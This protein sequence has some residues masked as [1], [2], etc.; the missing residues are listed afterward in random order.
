ME[1]KTLGGFVA[2]LALSMGS[3][4]G[5]GCGGDPS[6]D[7]SATNWGGGDD[8]TAGG[9]G[10]T[11]DDG[12]TGDD[13]GPEDDGDADAGDDNDGGSAG[14]DAD[15]GGDDGGVCSDRVCDE[16]ESCE[17]CP[18]D[19]GACDNPEG[20]PPEVPTPWDG[21]DSIPENSEVIESPSQSADVVFSCTGSP[22]NIVG[23]TANEPIVGTTDDTVTIN[24]SYCVIHDIVFEGYTVRVDGDHYVIRDSE[25]NGAGRTG[26]NGLSLAGSDGVA[27]RNASHHLL[28][29]DRHCYTNG[30]GATD[31]W[32]IENEGYYCTGDGY[33]AGHQQEAN[34]PT[35]IY[36]V[37][38][39]LHDNREN[40]L[41]YKFVQNVWAVENTLHGFA[42]A[43][44][45]EPWCFPDAPDQCSTSNSG[46]DGSAVVVGSD[47]GPIDSYHLRNVIYD[48]VTAIR[49]ESAFGEIH[50]VDNELTD[51]GNRCLALDKDGMDIQFTGNLCRGAERGIFQNWRVNFSLNVAGNTFEDISGPALEYEAGEV[52][53]ASTLTDNV[54]SNTGPVVYNNTTATTEAE[55][56]ALPQASGNMV[57]P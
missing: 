12:A 41:D 23:L 28:G 46:S 51:L 40:G 43:S 49:V 4:T 42:S 26:K 8:G 25:I 50:I 13:D 29:N 53:D 34:R 16:A 47:G 52:I 10:A 48:A 22:G 15:T 45:D 36:L 55:V 18:T 44:G 3:A 5:S 27:Y 54:F 56:N 9:D 17:T 31:T 14:D 32:F 57:S 37:R 21:W 19:C 2:T 20:W 38:N 1:L 11:D 39:H 33:Q 35:N 7:S 24:A 6:T 30:G